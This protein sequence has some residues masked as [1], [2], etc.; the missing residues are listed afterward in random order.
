M[1]PSPSPL[2]AAR[3]WPVALVALATL[4]LL[5]EGSVSLA[6]P[7]QLYDEG[8]PLVEAQRLARGER[9]WRD[10][11]PVYGP[12]EPALLAPAGGRLL[13]LR[14]LRAL[15]VA[16]AAAV[17]V[18]CALRLG[19]GAAAPLAALPLL[20]LA[21]PLTHPVL[22][23]VLASALALDRGHAGARPG[24]SAAAGALAGVAGLYRPEFGALA[25]A[26]AAATVL[27][28][29]WLAPGAPP[30]AR[31]LAALLAGALPGALAFLIVVV[32]GDAAGFVEH[33]RAVRAAMPF[34]A[35][36][37]PLAPPAG[38]GPIDLAGHLLLFLAPPLVAVAAPVALARR[39]LL[40]RRGAAPPPRPL[41]LHLVLLLL[42]LLPYALSRA[43]RSHLLPAL[44]AASPLLAAALG[45][46]VRGRG[47]A[48]L[49]AVA[50]ALP[51]AGR[52]GAAAHLALEPDL[53]RSRLPGLEG[54]LLPRALEEEYEALRRVVDA[55]AGPGGAVFVGCAEETP[56][57]IVPQHG[58]VHANDA[59]LYVVLDR[60]VGTRHHCFIPGVTTTAATQRRIVDDLARN[61]VR[62]VVLAFGTF[63][64][65]PNR[66]REAGARLLDQA[67]TAGWAPVAELRRW[68]VLAREP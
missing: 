47:A 42:G 40:A 60:P 12:L 29:P 52:A 8:F 46:V 23:P 61:D 21:G 54:V 53:V 4:A 50:L 6:A 38:L 49:A 63:R 13:A 65:E 22:L 35:L 66:S 9:P 34:R 33:A 30:R 27:A 32:A 56:R 39:A 67:L 41:E 55:H 48:A 1:D 57:A 62:V 24:W 20:W 15:S 19:A 11:D 37:Y 18:A 26:A 5:F 7:V 10:Y 68:V 51:V 45:G 43:D 28:R 16:G 58:R 36:D 25:L 2:A 14:A 31:A 59:L 64:D 3:A 44:A 17:A